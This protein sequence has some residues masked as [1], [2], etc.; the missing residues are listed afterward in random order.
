[1]RYILVISILFVVLTGCEIDYLKDPEI[2]PECS[3][4][5][6]T[7]QCATANEYCNNGVCFNKVNPCSKS[8]PN[9]FCDTPGASCQS[10][11]CVAPCIAQSCSDLGYQCGDQTDNCGEKIRCGS[12]SGTDICNSG[13]CEVPCEAKSC[14]DLGFECGEQLDNCNHAISCG[15]CDVGHCVIGIC[16]LPCES[17]TCDQLSYQCGDQV[18]NCGNVLPCG[19]CADGLVCDSGSCVATCTP[20]SCEDLGF[21]CGSQTDNCGDPVTCGGCGDNET[22]NDQGQCESTLILCSTEHPEGVCTEENDTCM[23]GSCV[24]IIQLGTFDINGTFAQKQHLVA[25]SKSGSITVESLTDVY[26]FQKLERIAGTNRVTVTSQ[27]CAIDVEVDAFTGDTTIPEL[28]INALN[29]PERTPNPPTYEYQIQKNEI[30][31]IMI[32]LNRLTELKGI[33]L[34]DPDIESLPASMDSDDPR[35][36][37]QDEDGHPG[38]SVWVNIFGDKRL[39]IAQRTKTE[40]SARISDANGFAANGQDNDDDDNYIWWSDEQAVLEKES[41]MIG[42]VM[43]ITSKNS[44]NYMNTVRIDDSWSCSDILSNKGSLF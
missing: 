37:D 36:F 41:P 38:M 35:V 21:Q 28:Y 13:I 20:K 32:V 14:S 22:C 3:P 8:F 16:E 33:H 17:Q 11:K 42:K 40:F 19:D 34:T 26:L 29:D 2:N 30:G 24:E 6:P 1:M 43:T 27:T 10:G 5:Y 18:D 4:L 39:C 9:G 44:K 25:D 7:G 12:C 23:N 15:V 31:E